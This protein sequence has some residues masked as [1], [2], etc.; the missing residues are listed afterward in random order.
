MF[1]FW[2]QI[3]SKTCTAPQLEPFLEPQMYMNPVFLNLSINTFNIYIIM[4][5]YKSTDIPFYIIPNDK[6]EG[7]LN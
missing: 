2:F 6:D 4:K 3:P 5:Q 7:H 1:E